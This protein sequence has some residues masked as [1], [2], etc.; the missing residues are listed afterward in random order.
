M[1][2]VKRIFNGYLAK[3]YPIYIFSPSDRSKS[4][5]SS[6]LKYKELELEGTPRYF[7]STTGSRLNGSLRWPREGTVLDTRAVSNRY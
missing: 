6:E 1:L 7:P 4:N 2:G 3:G 5:R